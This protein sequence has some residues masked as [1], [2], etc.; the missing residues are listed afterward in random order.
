MTDVWDLK[1]Q[2]VVKEAQNQGFSVLTDTMDVTKIP[3]VHFGD[4][5][6]FE[7]SYEVIL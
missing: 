3:C 1:M 2:V 6:V 5:R 7:A 4:V